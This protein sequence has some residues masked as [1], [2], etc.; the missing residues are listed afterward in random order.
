[1]NAKYTPCSFQ[2]LLR[3]ALSLPLY[4]IAKGRFWKYE[5]KL[6]NWRVLSEIEPVAFTRMIMSYEY[7]RTVTETSASL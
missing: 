6:E 3:C 7:G 4:E 1:M 5:E 2:K